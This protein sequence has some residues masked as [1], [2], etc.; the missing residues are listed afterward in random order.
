M[1]VIV[2]VVG[3]ILGFVGARLWQKTPS[4]M[5]DNLSFAK[6]EKKVKYWVAPM[7]PAYRRDKPGKSPMGMDMVP[8]YEENDQANSDDKNSIKI[9]SRVINNLGVITIKAKS[10]KVSREIETVGYV[11]ANEDN[12]ENIHSYI[13]GWVRDLKVSAV[14]DVV[15]KGEVLFKLYSPSL[16]NAQQEFILAV[17]NNNR[18]L[19]D[20]G[21]KKLITLGLNNTQINTLQRTRKA[22]QEIAIYSKANGI[23]S[24]LHI[25]DG[26]YIKPDK[27]LMVIEDL[28]TIWIRVEI[29]EKQANWVKT[30]QT[31]IASFPGLP[32]KQWQGQVIYVY[33]TLDKTTHTLAARLQF[34]NPD[35]E[36][37][38]D[39][40]A[41]V[42]ILVP[43]PKKAIVI[44]GSAVI[45]TEKGSHVILSLGQ[46]R[47]RAKEVVLGDESNGNVVV[48]SGLDVGNEVVVSGQ[49][50]IDSESNLS[51]AFTRLSPHKKKAV[52][53][54]PMPPVKNK[55]NK[56]RLLAID[57]NKHQITISHLPIKS[58]S[59]P[60][61]VMALPVAKEIDLSG[62][63][64]GE[65]IEINLLE[66]SPSHYKV[67]NIK[68]VSKDQP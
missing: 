68:P 67:I 46:G 17:K 33:P 40:Y 13:D 28:S 21:K 54:H 38:P 12:I 4:Q 7:N 14:G 23:L 11:S 51:A 20:A 53:H 62:F 25:R 39:M 34:P 35:F 56:A 6:K 41:A 48:L 64:V 29:V 15:K 44:P 61:M 36:L 42:K 32:G 45:R 2:L 5:G 19:I 50:L 66:E 65:M 3:V 8:V 18:Q 55:P 52:Y 31:A 57:L 24:K 47:F 37:K 22:K 60:E 30:N 59:M 43:S 49:F 27:E 63:K 10:A 58:M 1:I 26:M 9:S 16:I